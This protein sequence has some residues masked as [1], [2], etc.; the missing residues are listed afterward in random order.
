MAEERTP[1]LHEDAELFRAALSFTERDTGFS[2]RLVEK[3]YFCTVML[4]DLRGPFARGLV[5]KGGTSLSKVH[6]DFCRLSEDLDFVL[7]MPVDSSRAERRAAIAP[8]K[9]HFS[10]LPARLR[11]F[12]RAEPLG[13]FNLSTQ[14]VGRFTYESLV[15]GQDESIKVEIGLREP[16]VEPSENGAARTLVTNPFRGKPAV[17]PIAVNTL[18]FRE[19][20]AEKFRAA[21]TRREPAIRDYYDIDYAVT[22]GRLQTNQ[23]RLLDLVRKKLAAARNPPVDVAE[24]RLVALRHQLA[25]QL[26]PV[27]RTADFETFDLERAFRT[28]C[29]L[30]NQL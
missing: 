11:C 3:D 29:T 7:S 9:A 25:G 21:L 23:S 13:G 2:A 26:Q 10:A 12:E 17:E 30:A 8:L 28:V 16:L 19:T 15:T 18:S 5:F 6:A 20:Y 4:A 24:S 1:R 22:T 27:L 14:Y